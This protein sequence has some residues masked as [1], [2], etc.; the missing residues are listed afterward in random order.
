MKKSHPVG[1]ANQRMLSF[2]ACGEPLDLWSQWS[3]AQQEECRQLLRQL[4][5]TVARHQRN[6]GRAE[7]ASLEQN[8]E[9]SRWTN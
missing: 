8:Q 3:D 5:L 6:A 1:R 9:H 2:P 7:S 4:L